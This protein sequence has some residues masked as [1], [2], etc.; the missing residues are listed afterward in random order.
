MNN[1]KGSP[2][3]P[4]KMPQ[5]KNWRSLTKTNGRLLLG[6]LVCLSAAFSTNIYKIRPADDD[7]TSGF[8]V[9]S[10]LE[11][12]TFATEPSLRNPTNMDI[13]AKGRIWVC[14]GVNYRPK[15][16]P[17]NKG[18][19]E[20]DRILILEDTDG[21]GKA[22]KEKV[23]YQ[24]ND[25]NAALGIAVLGNKAIVSV[26]PNVFIF[27]D[28]DG[29]D[30]ADKKELLFTGLGGEQHDHAV[31]A[32]TFGPDG[33]LYFNFGNEGKQIKDKDGKPLVDREGNEI[34][35]NGKPYRQGMV[36]RCDLD[37]SNIEVLAHN[38]RNNYEVAVDSYGTLWQSD[39]DDD[40]NRGVRINY[41]MPYGNYG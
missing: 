30:K 7:L 37:G 25:V 8:E 16:N 23:F 11:V 38:F 33:K 35:N 3:N 2:T 34:A 10:G 40:G 36:F 26:S 24:G 9:A 14:E 15:L 6:G 5:N 20:G 41:V 17:N 12:K 19:D 32:F 22:D 18:Q 21:D 1:K 31:H 4:E 28:T 13:D 39:N 29:D 27:T